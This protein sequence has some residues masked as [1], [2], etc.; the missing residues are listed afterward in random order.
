M[1]MNRRDALKTIGGLAGA[2]TLG[3]FLPACSSDGKEGITTYVFLML[4][5]RSYDHVFGA[6][7]WKEGKPGDGLTD[8][9]SQPDL[10]D[11]PVAPYQPTNLAQQMC[12]SNDPPHSWSPSR[13]Q[14][15][16]GANDGFVKVH[17]AKYSGAI[18]PMQYL[19]RK[20]QPVSWALADAYTSCDK[21]HCSLMCGTLPNRF[22]W[23]AGTSA[24]YRTNDVATNTDRPLDVDT[25]YHRLRDKGIDWRYYFGNLPVIS[26]ANARLTPARQFSNEYL[27][28][29]VRNFGDSEYAEGQFFR[30]AMQG[31]LPPVTYIDPAFY[32]NDDHPPT[33]PILAQA[34]I[35][36]IYTALANSP[37]WKNCLFVVTYDEH[38]GFYDHVAPP[39]LPASAD[40]TATRF[41]V[42]EDGR[43]TSGDNEFTQ[44]GFRVPALV[45]GP[46]VKQGYVSSVHYDHTS[47]LKHLQNV[48]DLDPLTARVDAANDLSDCIDLERLAA[49][50]W[51][52]PVQMPQFEF[53]HDSTGEIT[54]VTVG[55]ER[56]PYTKSICAPGISGFRTECPVNSVALQRPEM[57]EGFDLRDSEGAYIDSIHRF[58]AA[59]QGKLGS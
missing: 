33:H 59:N 21:W 54:A 8:A 25:V 7:S 11:M 19:T 23:H 50:D 49:G 15:N 41:P 1:S 45:V 24:G 52:P 36:S 34:L 27:Q 10:N 46:Y 29:S 37:Q 51:A 42:D 47:A 12:V 48:F 9:S 22:Y 20:E 40:D 26:V 30:D 13:Q 39:N 5:N 43:T 32:V 57:F 18:E 55:G 14:F 58:L 17:Q 2:A 16:S 4:E 38:G 56:W 28:A 53:E 44:L 35:A 3:K 6:R 31:T